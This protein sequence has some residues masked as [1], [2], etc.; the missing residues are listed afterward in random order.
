MEYELFLY[1]HSIL[2]I[3]CIH[4]KVVIMEN[5]TYLRNMDSCK[6][7]APVQLPQFKPYLT[8]YNLSHISSFPSQWVLMLNLFTRF[9]S[10][11]R[12]GSCL[13][14]DSS[15]GNTKPP[16]IPNQQGLNTRP[17]LYISHSTR[18]DFVPTGKPRATVPRGPRVYLTSHYLVSIT[19]ASCCGHIR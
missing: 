7:F 8:M 16:K 18:C 5:K 19:V 15:G 13:C 12:S 4:I 14:W 1:Y 9:A 6:F 10:G 11:R 17:Q 3:S 2:I